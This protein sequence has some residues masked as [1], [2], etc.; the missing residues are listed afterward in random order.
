[1]EPGAQWSYSGGGYTLLRLVIE[2][3]TGETFSAYMQREV[4]EPLGMAHSSFHWRADLRPATAVGYSESGSAQPNY[5]L[6]E[7]AAAGLYTTAPDLAL[8]VA[9]AMPGPNGEPAGRGVQAPDTLARMITPA[10]RL[11]SP[12]DAWGLGHGLLALSDGSCGI[13][14]GGSNRGWSAF[15]EAAP[16]WGKGIVVLT[17]SDNGMKLIEPVV[18]ACVEELVSRSTREGGNPSEQGTRTSSTEQEQPRHVDSGQKYS[19]PEPL[20]CPPFP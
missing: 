20:S 5:L 18:G 13:R 4:L 8:L 6:T 10:V 2:E 15:F 12:G 11:Q 17:N 9:T 7:Q 16:T 14:W 3:V 19:T 1:M